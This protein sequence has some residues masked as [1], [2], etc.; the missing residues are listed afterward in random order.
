MVDRGIPH[1]SNRAD[2]HGAR[3]NESL[4]NNCLFFTGT[5]TLC[6]DLCSSQWG[7]YMNIPLQDGRRETFSL[8]VAGAMCGADAARLAGY[9]PEHPRNARVMAWYLLKRPDVQDRIAQIREAASDKAIMD[10]TQ[11]KIVLSQIARA[12]M[13]DYRDERGKFI[14]LDKDVPNPSAIASVEYAYD[15]VKREPYPTRIILRDPIGAIVELCKIDGLYLKRKVEVQMSPVTHVSVVQSARAKISARI[16]AIN[17]VNNDRGNMDR[18]LEDR[19]SEEQD[20]G[21]A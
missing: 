6:K 21:G 13:C 16:S 3:T 15:P 10:L 12:R 14:P 9:C 8:N 19:C 4:M 11:C 5:T 2:G 17:G 20:D 7:C 1:H 18:E